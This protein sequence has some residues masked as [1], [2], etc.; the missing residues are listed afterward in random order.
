[1]FVAVFIALLTLVYIFLISFLIVYWN[2][3][4]VFR[5]PASFVPKTKISIVVPVRNE[6][7]HLANC[8]ESLLNQEYPG[9]L[10]EI[11]IVDDQS[12]DE[13]PDIATSF[14][15]PRIQY[16]RLGVEGRTTIEGSKKKAIA[17]GV[18]H[19]KG[20]L[21][22][23]TD[24]DCT[25]PARWLKS[26]AAQY[27]QDPVRLLSGAVIPAWGQGWFQAFISLDM[28]NT[29]VIQAVGIAS[30]SYFICSGAN[31]AYER[32]A[33]LESDPYEDNMQIASGDDTFLLDR[34]RI[35]YPGQLAILKSP[36]AVCLTESPADLSSFFS[37]RL[38]WAGKMK[39]T[40][41]T[42]TML[43]ATYIWLHRIIPL[44]AIII[45]LILHD[46]L[47]LLSGTIAIGIG[48][49]FN[50][51]MLY[52]AVSFFGRRKLLYW[53]IPS[54][55]FYTIYFVILGVLSWLPMQLEWKDRRLSI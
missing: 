30:G 32:K 4:P 55:I 38:R 14:D 41:G 46:H 6:A 51:A 26:I 37:Q 45:G 53:F 35:R 23:T 18:N 43:L 54:E 15:D 21:I 50:F 2:R 24:G 1:M 39:K 36:E 44:S 19:A 48:W 25:L 7:E 10:Y 9:D 47:Y 42:A 52:Q 29:F 31:L 12:Y 40:S 33:F 16:M 8:I 5:I 11:L 22:V 17:Y 49:L 13:T 3:V 28:M 34:F 27:E 20:T